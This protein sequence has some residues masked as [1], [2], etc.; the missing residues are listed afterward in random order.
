MFAQSNHPFIQPPLVK[1]PKSIWKG[2][3][4]LQNV[5]HL[6]IF[7]LLPL[8]QSQQVL[9]KVTDGRSF[10]GSLNLGHHRLQ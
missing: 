7:R 6:P 5:Q 9:S 10:E 8:G 1:L 2:Q 3:R 4:H